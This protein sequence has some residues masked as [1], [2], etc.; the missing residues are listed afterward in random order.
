MKTEQRG[1][2]LTLAK[3]VFTGGTITR[4]HF[5][6]KKQPIETIALYFTSQ[7][8]WY[9]LCWPQLGPRENCRISGL[10]QTYFTLAFAGDPNS[11]H[12][13]DLYEYESLRSRA[14]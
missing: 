12:D 11:N 5:L 13:C 1:M 3:Q 2:H 8:N 9:Q 14:L 4:P 10:S 7:I 6:A